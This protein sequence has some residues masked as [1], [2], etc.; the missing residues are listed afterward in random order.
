MSDPLSQF[1][2][3]IGSLSSSQSQESELLLMQLDEAGAHRLRLC[4]IPHTF[5]DKV[6]RTLDPDLNAED[7]EQTIQEFQKLPAVMAL[8]DCFMLHDVVRQQLFAQ[9]L[10]PERR[11]TFS[12]ASARLADFFRPQAN[13]NA[14]VAATKQLS[15]LFHLLGA[16]L[17]QGF[18]EFQSVYQARRE[19]GRFSECEAL[20][21]LL[22]EYAS[23]LGPRERN[24]LAYYQ[25]EIADDNRDWPRAVERLE[26]L[27]AQDLPDELRSLA[28]LRSGSVLRRLG[29]FAQA[30]ARCLEALQLAGRLGGGAAPHLIHHELGLIARDSNDFEGAR[31]QLERAI[32]LAKAAGDRLDVVIAYNSLGTLLRKPAPRDAARLFHECLALLDP[33]RDSLRIAQVLN[34]LGMANADIGEWRASEASY[35][36]SLEIKRASSDLYGQALTLLNVSRVYRAESRWNEARTALMDSAKLFEDVHDATHSGEAHRELARLMKTSG[37]PA[38]MEFH[39]SK[40]IECFQHAGND[41]EVQAIKREF[42]TGAVRKSKWR[43]R[44]TWTVI[45]AIGLVVVLILIA[46]IVDD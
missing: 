1:Q 25:A 28:L 33:K 26:A 13:D 39:A 46:L 15:R 14:V 36:Q 34:N 19:Q 37:T 5:D 18:R 40:A 2:E 3:L 7:A 38:E 29:R 22:R 9:W 4:A 27:L 6:L 11:E 43:R 41:S 12:A 30:Q 42:S 35:K 20:V 23:M 10:T 44:L 32:D 16:D 45:A 31:E 17:G 21:R 8:G 24:W